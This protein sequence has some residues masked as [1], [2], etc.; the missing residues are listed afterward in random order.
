MTED[1]ILHI[2]N[3][4]KDKI[5]I[6]KPS[7]N[8]DVQ[9]QALQNILVNILTKSVHRKMGGGVTFE[10]SNDEDKFFRE[11]IIY[12]RRQMGREEWVLVY[13]SF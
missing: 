3:I 9:T 1:N 4:I 11:L 6:E 12:R 8:I 13:T 10:T 2:K 5:D 7:N